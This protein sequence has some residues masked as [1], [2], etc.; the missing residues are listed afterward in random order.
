MLLSHLKLQMV[1]KINGLLLKLVIM[2]P[3]TFPKRALIAFCTLLLGT[4]S[5]DGLH[6][7]SLNHLQHLQN[8]KTEI[9]TEFS[10]LRDSLT[11]AILNWEPEELRMLGYFGTAGQL[12][13]W[14]PKAIA[15]Q[16]Q[17]CHESIQK[18]NKVQVSNPAEELDRAVLTAHLTYLEHYYG[19]YHGELGNL[20]IS[21]YPYDVI[22]YELQQFETGPRDSLSARSHFNA[23]EGILRQLPGYLEI[24]QSNLVAGIKLRQPDKEIL[25]RL[26]KRIGSSNDGSSIRSGLKEIKERIESVESQLLLPPFQ[27][28][29]LHDL[30]QQADAA[31]GVHLNF[32]KNDLRKLAGESWPLGKNEYIYRLSLLYGYDGSLDDLVR[33]AEENLDSLMKE[34]ISLAHELRPDL[35]LTDTL[36]LEVLEVLR[37]RR[38]VSEEEL[39]KAYQRIQKKIDDGITK[40][41]GLPVG[42][43]S[44]R[45]APLGVPVGSATNWPAPLLSRGAAIVLVNISSE[46]LE[47]NAYID[48][49]WIATHEG[50]PGHAAQSLFFQTAFNKG[51]ASLCRFLNVPDE[52]GYVRGNWYAM[53]NIEG[54]A[55]YC[56]RLLLASGLLTSEERLAALTGQALRAARVVVDVRM[57][58][59]GWSRKRATEY[60]IKKAGQN[61]ATAERE[62]YRYSRIPLQALSYYL[63][64][65]QFEELH[66]KYAVQFGDDFYRQVLLLGP[67]PPRLIDLYFQKH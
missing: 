34:I 49:L 4:S 12:K 31:Y 67:I 24:Q 6:Q 59:T 1:S 17:F 30:L 47:E 15:K 25:D 26:T 38:A 44:Y 42:A 65:R 64:A 60:L 16:V 22:Q 33:G 18:L 45:S 40:L 51:G 56:E 58:T 10:R 2:K 21:A 46:G 9:P 19:Q 3:Y 32:L 39:L 66:R 50:N 11:V 7:D 14:S 52:I 53:E 27:K 5:Q 36:H 63:G 55:L 23:I 35:P 28:E 62:S 48:L 41:L 61:R 20:Q 8:A 29:V 13:D 54:W 43:A 57:H 37:Q